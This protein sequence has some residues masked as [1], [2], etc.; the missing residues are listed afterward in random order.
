MPNREL[1][2]NVY[3]IIAS[4]VEDKGIKVS[5]DSPL[6]G[7]D[8]ILDSV[9]L[10]E[11]FLLLEDMATDLGFS[12]DWASSTSMDKSHGIFSTASAIATEFISQFQIKREA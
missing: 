4:I 2:Q 6:T 5:D 8:S 12:F 9:K 10:V 1:K 7:N 11:L 3:N